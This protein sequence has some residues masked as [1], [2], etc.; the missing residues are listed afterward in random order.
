M[1]LKCLGQ[2]DRS[3][4]I[5][6]EPREPVRRAQG[7]MVGKAKKAGACQPCEGR[8]AVVGSY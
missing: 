6:R 4:S 5:Y 1:E 3:R 2:L 8:M 7:S